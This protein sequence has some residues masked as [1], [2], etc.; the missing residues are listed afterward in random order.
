MWDSIDFVAC[1]FDC[2]LSIFQ[3]FQVHQW[4]G[5]I[6]G[7]SLYS[8]FSNCNL[9]QW[10]LFI[11]KIITK[12]V[13]YPI[14]EFQYKCLFWHILLEPVLIQPEL[15]SVTLQLHGHFH[16]STLWQCLLRLYLTI[17]WLCSMHLAL[18]V[19][20]PQVDGISSLLCKGSS[21]WWCSR[22]LFKNQCFHKLRQWIAVTNHYI[23][24]FR[25]K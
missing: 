15:G 17:L 7:F 6:V 9:F 14:C 4:D 21:G 18:Q 13:L 19:M 1:M 22:F 10:Y 3:L 2:L 12:Q 24:R 25:H 8:K 23:I 20:A 5:K 11:N 16:H